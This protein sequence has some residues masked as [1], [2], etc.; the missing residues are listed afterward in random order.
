MND[1]S[2]PSGIFHVLSICEHRRH[3]RKNSGITRL[4]ALGAIRSLSNL[5]MNKPQADGAGALKVY[6]ALAWR[7]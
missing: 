3:L 2:P 6:L 4:T 5:N 1:P 7:I